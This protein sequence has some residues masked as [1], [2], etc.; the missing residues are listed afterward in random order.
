MPATI[1]TI[2][3]NGLRF[4]TLEWGKTGPL[5]V[6]FHGFPDTAYTWDVLGPALAEAGYRVV[7]PF[8]RGYAPTALP[9]TDT[10]SRTLGQ[11]VLGILAALT[12]GPVRVVG[13]DWGAEAVYA[14]MGLDAS[15]IARAATIAIPHRAAVPFTPS[16]V[17]ALRHFATLRLPGAERRFADALIPFLR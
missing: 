9:S 16:L 12:D 13:H 2:D 8:L 1:G 5:V 4:A 17:W 14:A 10:D 7:A 6:C 3:A 15:R 11:D